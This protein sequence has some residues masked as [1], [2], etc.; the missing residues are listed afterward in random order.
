MKC[1]V[2]W[3]N[4]HFISYCRCRCAEFA[5]DFFFV[6]RIS[7]LSW[8]DF[9]FYFCVHLPNEASASDKSDS[10]G[11]F[12]M[13]RMPPSSGSS[14]NSIGGPP[15]KHWK[16]QM[17]WVE[18]LLRAIVL[19]AFNAESGRE[20]WRA[21]SCGHQLMNHNNER[22]DIIVRSNF[23]LPFCLSTSLRSDFA[24]VCGA[25]HRHRPIEPLARSRSV[26]K[27]YLLSATSPFS[28]ISRVPATI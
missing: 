20:E 25:T 15:S 28:P 22:Y 14:F 9:F 18:Y 4:C 23:F 19:Y 13:L 17:K 1:V 6:L 11:T 21:A 3:L 7:R 26:N 27:A 2:C 10:D 5:I 12:W 24:A 16:W 8:G